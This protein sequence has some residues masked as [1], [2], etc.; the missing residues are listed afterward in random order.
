MSFPNAF[1]KS[2]IN[3]EK[4]VSCPMQYL[5]NMG[6]DQKPRYSSC[7]VTKTD[8]FKILL[9][10]LHKY[11]TLRY[12]EKVT[13]YS[14]NHKNTNLC[15]R[16]SKTSQKCH[17]TVEL[18]DSKSQTI[19]KNPQI[20]ICDVNICD[21]NSQ[22]NEKSHK[23]VSLCDKKPQTTVKNYKNVSLKDKKSQTSKTCQKM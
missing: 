16:K 13:T 10:Y 15:D 21:E 3:R 22:T 12:I 23:N 17:K 19:V 1:N 4:I 18:C 9:F 11:D 5:K 20:N 6:N 2:F 7:V 14:K 8:S